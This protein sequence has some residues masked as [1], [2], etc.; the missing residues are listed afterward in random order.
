MGYN[1]LEE[2]VW[3]LRILLVLT[4]AGLILRELVHTEGSITPVP[5][6]LF[7]YPQ[8]DS[9]GRRKVNWVQSLGL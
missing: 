6:T 5:S 3:L 2:P 9:K 8:Q 7:P 1:R 4:M